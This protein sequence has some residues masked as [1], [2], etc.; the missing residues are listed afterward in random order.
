MIVA[1]V[2]GYSALVLEQVSMSRLF[3]SACKRIMLPMVLAMVASG[4][5][6]PV[7]PARAQ[8]DSQ[9]FF[10]K[11]YARSVGSEAG[12]PN[13]AALGARQAP[14]GSPN[15]AASGAGYPSTAQIES[16][17]PGSL[18]QIPLLASLYVNSKDSKHLNEVVSKALLLRRQS[19]LY[20]VAI[21]HIGD[22]RTLSAENQALIKKYGIPYEAV[23]KVPYSLNVMMSPTWA[24]MKNGQ[25]RLVEGYLNVE[26]F[27]S[28]EGL[29]PPTVKIDSIP[30]DSGKLAG[31]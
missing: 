4:V 10:G 28:S 5:C 27:I 31:F 3:F 15:A 2:E 16:A 1:R 24:F 23:A 7:R 19:K 11:D 13:T 8:D 6:Y 29:L 25:V 14:R 22:Y 9:Q 26:P 12:A 17:P 20:L 30:L 21:Y 18:P